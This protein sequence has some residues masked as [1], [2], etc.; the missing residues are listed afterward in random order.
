M[1][2]KKSLK[3]VLILDSSYKM[4]SIELLNPDP[5]LVNRMKSSKG[6]MISLKVEQ[7]GK[8]LKQILWKK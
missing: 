7:F 3:I 5:I 4:R 8:I 6:Q 2:T 1:M